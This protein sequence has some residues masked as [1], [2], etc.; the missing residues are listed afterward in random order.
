[1]YGLFSEL[2]LVPWICQAPRQDAVDRRESPE[3]A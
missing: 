3:P 1:M 2:S